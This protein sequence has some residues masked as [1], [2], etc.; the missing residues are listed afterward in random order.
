MEYFG[1]ASLVPLV[2]QIARALLRAIRPKQWTNNRLVYLALFPAIPVGDLRKLSR[3]IHSDSYQDYVFKD[4][5]LVGQFDEMYRRFSDPWNCVADSASLESDVFCTLLRWIS[6]DVSRVLDVGC[7]LGA[8]TARIHMAVAP[9]EVSAIDVSG[10][11][12]EKAKKTY[13]GI[14]FS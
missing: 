3:L 6:R 13:P 10:D 4:G 11:A 5:E 7:G 12:I 1:N 14:H 2:P 8:L 9:A